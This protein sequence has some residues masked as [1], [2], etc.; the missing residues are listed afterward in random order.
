[1]TLLGIIHADE[2]IFKEFLHFPKIA[3]TE[4]DITF[5][6]GPSG[7]GKSTL[8]QLINGTISPDTGTIQFRGKDIASIDPIELRRKVLL[9]GQTVYLFK[10]T[11]QENFRFFHKANESAIPNNEQIKKYLHICGV[12]FDLDAKC[13]YLSGGERQRVFLAIALSMTP[14]VLLLDEPTAAL[15]EKTAHA[16]FK[17]ISEHCKRHGITLVVVSHASTLTE[18]FAEHIVSLGGVKA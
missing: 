7:C 10:G 8:L 17:N 13:D 12:E 18:E 5:I 16:V 15:D 2:L 1:M 9:V 4:G 14:E 3:I 11:I 6:T